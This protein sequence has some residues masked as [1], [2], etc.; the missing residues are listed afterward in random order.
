MKKIALIA[1]GVMLASSL[2]MVPGIAAAQGGYSS[3]QS[4]PAIYG[5]GGIT[6]FRLNDDDFLAENED[7]DKEFK[8]NRTGWRAQI[9]T[10]INPIFSI[11][12]GYLDLGDLNDGDFR[13]SSDGGFAAALVHVPLGTIS[14][15]AKIGNFWWDV[16]RDAPG[17]GGP[18]DDAL[19]TSRSGNDMFY[20]FGV[21]IGEG[22]GLQLRV[23]YDRME[24]DNADVDMGSVNLQYLF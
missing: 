20:G 18:L 22:P 23:E 6:Y 8:D 17:A 14:P 13:L 11:E 15:F 19:S 10:Q 3:Q 9:G 16:D 24:V 5:G 1:P 4:G 12:G 21:R 7:G 2:A